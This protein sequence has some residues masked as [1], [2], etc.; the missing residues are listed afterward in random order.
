MVTSDF[1]DTY[2]NACFTN[3]VFEVILLENLSIKFNFKVSNQQAMS[4]NIFLT[5]KS[6]ASLKEVIAEHLSNLTSI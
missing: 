3:S 5:R 6:F 4:K 2:A 1:I